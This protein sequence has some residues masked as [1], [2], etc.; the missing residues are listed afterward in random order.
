ME[1]KYVITCEATKEA[2]W[3]QKFLMDLQVVPATS[4]SMTLCCDSSGVV[5]NSKESRNHKIAKH[6]ERK[7]HLIRDIV[8]QREVT[9]CKITS[10][11]NLADPFMKVP[12]AKS[13]DGYLV[14]LGMKKM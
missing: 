9:V 13:F 7:C 2:I 8:E 4:H 6:I 10:K 5:V 3:L 11:E 12:S 1:A 14:N